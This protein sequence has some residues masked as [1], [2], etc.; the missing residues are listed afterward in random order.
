METQS[1]NFSLGFSDNFHNFLVGTSGIFWWLCPLSG[2]GFWRR[3]PDHPEAGL[4][5][6]FTGIWAG[7]SGQIG[8]EGRL[9]RSG[10]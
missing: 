10:G 4:S 8:K 9:G 3:F 6:H 2:G 1:D 5:G 7:F